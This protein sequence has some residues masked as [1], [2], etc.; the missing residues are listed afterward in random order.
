MHEKI[1][2]LNDKIERETFDK[3]GYDFVDFDNNL[4][5]K[6]L[7]KKR[8]YFF[9]SKIPSIVTSFVFSGIIVLAQNK[10]ST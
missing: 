1:E 9:S 4:S 6:V 10:D 2:L 5:N 8:N 3:P 7:N